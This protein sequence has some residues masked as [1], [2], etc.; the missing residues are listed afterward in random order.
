[1]GSV[2]AEQLVRAGVGFLR[3]ADRDVVE[4]TNLQR[5]ILFDEND[6]AEQTPK[7]VAAARRLG[8]INSEV[9]I[10][11][12]VC[13]V[14]AGNIEALADCDL[15]LDGADNV[16]TRYLI[17]DVSVKQALP[18]VYGACVGAEGRCMAIWPPTDACLRCVFP[19]PPS[20]AELPTCDTS[21]VLGAAA[22][23]VASLQV[24]AAIRLLLGDHR[25]QELVSVAVWSNRFRTI[26]L[27]EAKRPDCP[28]C[29]LRQFEFLNTPTAGRSASL[30]GRNAIQVRPSRT[31]DPLDLAA[32]AAKLSTAGAVQKTAYLVRCDLHEPRD[33]RLTVFPDGRAIVYG[34]ADAERARSVYARFVGT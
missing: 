14:H 5:Q 4:L 18:W 28:S 23:I 30:C 26:S 3:I 12:L 9:R 29:G 16:E 27:A 1:L 11:P 22:A 8:E 33:L 25:D 10:E 7:A 31:A 19:Q 20:A 13:D 2:I 6:V 15:I 34:T 24:T 21:G 17:N 32:V